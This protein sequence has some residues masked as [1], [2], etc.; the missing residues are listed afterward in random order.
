MLLDVS[1][2]MEKLVRDGTELNANARVLDEFLRLFVDL[3]PLAE[4]LNEVGMFHQSKTMT[5]ALRV[6]SDGIEEVGVLWICGASS[7]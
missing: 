1:A 2:Q 3:F 4:L 6:E 5:N 7:I